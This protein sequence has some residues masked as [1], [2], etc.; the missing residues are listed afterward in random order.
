MKANWAIST[1]TYTYRSAE[2]GEPELTSFTQNLTFADAVYLFRNA[3]SENGI[4]TDSYPCSINHPPRWL[5]ANGTMHYRSGETENV[6]LHI[7]EQVTPS[8]RMRL[9][10]L[11]CSK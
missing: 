10:R 8:S 5:T 2:H 7:P 4:Y 1:E 11:L 9:M 3:D 6:T